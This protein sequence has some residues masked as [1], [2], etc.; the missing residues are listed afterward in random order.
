[1]TDRPIESER[2][3]LTGADALRGALF[4]RGERVVA[5]VDGAALDGV[6]ARLFAPNIVHFCLLPGE[7][8][9]DMALVAP[10]LV[11]LDP[12]SPLTAWLTTEAWGKH[13]CI[14]ASSKVDIRILRNH[15][16][17]LVWTLSPEGR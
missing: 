8:P 2:T 7:L 14:F 17:A 6:V 5:V 3:P 1:M 12:E 4:G 13:G 10:Y 16:R 15:F 11:E 9:P